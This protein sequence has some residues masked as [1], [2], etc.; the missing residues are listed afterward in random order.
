LVVL[1]VSEDVLLLSGDVVIF[2][3]GADDDE[4]AEENVRGE[5]LLLGRIA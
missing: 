1:L 4:Y 2:Q 5:V 3:I